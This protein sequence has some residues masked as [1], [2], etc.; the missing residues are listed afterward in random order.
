MLSDVSAATWWDEATPRSA[1]PPPANIIKGAALPVTPPGHTSTAV[2]SAPVAASASAWSDEPWWVYDAA[3]VLECDDTD[4]LASACAEPE[5]SCRAWIRA[6]EAIAPIA[7]TDRKMG[8]GS[9]GRVQ[10]AAALTHAATCTESPG[11]ASFLHGALLHGTSVAKA[12][13]LWLDAQVRSAYTSNV[14]TSP[15]PSAPLTV[16]LACGRF[17]MPRCAGR[18]QRLSLPQPSRP[19]AS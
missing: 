14:S 13:A 1:L 6:V 3:C 11:V 5:A 16:A 18:V 8:V 4:L 17:S 15:P 12:C 10:I 9:V 7:S 19:T 2:G